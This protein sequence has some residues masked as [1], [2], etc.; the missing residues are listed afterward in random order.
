[1]RKGFS[2]KSH[3]SSSLGLRFAPVLARREAELRAI[4]HAAQVVENDRTD[5]QDG[6]TDFKDI[7]GTLP[8]GRR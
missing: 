7:G 5:G 3:D 6:V 8:G 2:M 4:L 1:M